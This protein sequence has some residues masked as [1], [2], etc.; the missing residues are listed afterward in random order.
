MS[1]VSFKHHFHDGSNKLISKVEILMSRTFFA[2]WLTYKEGKS[3]TL[4]MPYQP[5]HVKSCTLEG[6]LDLRIINSSDFN[7]DW[8]KGVPV[9]KHSHMKRSMRKQSCSFYFLYYFSNFILG[10]FL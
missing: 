7:K 3:P 4:G 1:F 2:G 10:F 5:L 8:P 9:A 6:S